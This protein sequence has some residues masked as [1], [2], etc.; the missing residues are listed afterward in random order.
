MSDI[1]TD[2]FATQRKRIVETLRN[3]EFIPRVRELEARGALYWKVK[4]LNHNLGYE[5]QCD[6]PANQFPA[7]LPL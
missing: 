3:D 1:Q 2:L 5:V 4:V 7:E 6:V